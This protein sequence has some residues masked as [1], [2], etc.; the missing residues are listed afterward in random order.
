MLKAKI[1]NISGYKGWDDYDGPGDNNMNF[2]VILD[3]R[4]TK[5][6]VEEIFVNRYTKKHR[7]VVVEA[8]EKAEYNVVG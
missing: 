7:V 3:A 2:N 8:Q 1:W 5:E 4:F 6:E